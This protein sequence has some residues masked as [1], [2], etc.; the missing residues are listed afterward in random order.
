MCSSTRMTIKICNKFLTF[1]V[2]IYMYIVNIP[3][4]IPF[5]LYSRIAAP[6][7]SSS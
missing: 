7:W 1:A 6:V 4:T 2:K 3:V 5:K